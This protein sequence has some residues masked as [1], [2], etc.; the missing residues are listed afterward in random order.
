[1]AGALG[2]PSAREAVVVDHDWGRAGRLA[3]RHAA[4]KSRLAG[5]SKFRK[6]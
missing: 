4:P 2:A 3:L 5:S 6:F 1:M